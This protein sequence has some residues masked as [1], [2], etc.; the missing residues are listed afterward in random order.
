[1]L[2]DLRHRADRVRQRRARV[3]RAVR[4]GA[5][6]R[7]GVPRDRAG[8]PLRDLRRRR[9]RLRR[10][11]RRRGRADGNGCDAT[12]QLE[13]SVCGN[14][15]VERG[16]TCDEGDAVDGDGCSSVCLIEGVDPPVPPPPAGGCG[17]SA[18]ASDRGAP[19]A[20]VALGLALCVLG[21][22]GRAPRGRRSRG[23]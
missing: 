11:V 22:R 1:M 20:L 16:E 23:A 6:V 5:G 21:R 17:C 4:L 3:R 14:G 8:E 9:A 15:R 10:A 19:L 13:A 7:R 18:P 12:C 2:V